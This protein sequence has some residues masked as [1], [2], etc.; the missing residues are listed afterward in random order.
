[1]G[2]PLEGEHSFTA[3]GQTYTLAISWRAL[4]SA[5]READRSTAWL[6]THL[7]WLSTLEVLFHHGLKRY[8]PRITLDEVDAILTELTIPGAVKVIEAA[9]VTAFPKEKSEPSP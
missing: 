5:E 2:N 4:A 1:M 8:H 7:D 6:L 9:L 3:K